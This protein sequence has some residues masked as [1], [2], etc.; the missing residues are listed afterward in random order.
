M[1]AAA[2]ARRRFGRPHTMIASG[3]TAQFDPEAPVRFMAASALL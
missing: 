3:L 2:A 1:L